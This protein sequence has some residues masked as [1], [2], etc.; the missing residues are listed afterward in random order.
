MRALSTANPFLT[1]F[2]AGRRKGVSPILRDRIDRTEADLRLAIELAEVDVLG[3]DEL[4]LVAAEREF[5]PVAAVA[6]VLPLPLLPTVL[7]HYLTDPLYLPT[8]AD[9]A[10][11]R[12]DT[13]AAMVR[14]LAGDPDLV[15][16]T[17]ALRRLDERIRMEHATLRAGRP[18]LRVRRVRG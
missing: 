7:Q 10:R 17:R 1:T 11:D 16:A 9:E 5:E 18:R 14:S 12:L 3:P 8:V 13:C 4:A 2:F 15:G 6:R